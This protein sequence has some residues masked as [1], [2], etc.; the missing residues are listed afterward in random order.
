MDFQLLKGPNRIILLK[1][2]R[3]LINVTNTI[4]WCIKTT[5]TFIIS[6]KDFDGRVL[7][8]INLMFKDLQG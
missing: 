2:N 4:R 1:I 7:S 5:R 8:I 6:E 3:W